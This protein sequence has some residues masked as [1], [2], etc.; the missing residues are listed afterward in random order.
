MCLRSLS[1]AT[2]IPSNSH[3]TSC[4]P[5]RTQPPFFI[6][7]LVPSA[8]PCTHPAEQSEGGCRHAVVLPHRGAAAEREGHLRDPRGRQAELRHLGALRLL[9]AQEERAVRAAP[10]RR[11]GDTFRPPREPPA[12]RLASPFPSAAGRRPSSSSS[13]RRWQP[14]GYN[15]LPVHPA[16]M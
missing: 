7:N 3:C 11:K 5:L 6:K 10:R 16:V 13:S 12:G 14:R 9:R 1:K 2:G 8:P 15:V 4:E